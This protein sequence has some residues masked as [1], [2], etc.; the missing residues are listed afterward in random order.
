MTTVKKIVS[1]QEALRLGLTRYFTGK[2][3]KNGHVDERLAKSRGCL[4]CR[5]QFNKEALQ[6]A[7][8]AGK[9]WVTSIS[10]RSYAN[11]SEKAKQASQAWRYRNKER[12]KENFRKWHK[13]NR[14]L[15]N[16]H[17]S[18]RKARKIQATPPWVDLGEIKEIYRNCPEGYHVDHIMPLVHKELC[19]LH[20]PWN[21]QY[22]SA[23]QNMS[24]GNRIV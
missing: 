1:R 15:C 8:E 9:E 21:L 3:C 20:V 4:T 16:H 10:R 11:N 23:S 24:K 13:A 6:R 12:C 18:L 5:V 2:P 22:L 19:G 17:A 14:P 7:R